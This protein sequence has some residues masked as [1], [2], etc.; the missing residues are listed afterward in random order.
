MSGASLLLNFQKS[1]SHFVSKL[2]TSLAVS[3][4]SLVYKLQ[5]NQD[6]NSN[7]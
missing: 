3:V 5:V 1:A 7:E 4:A 2:I 6:S